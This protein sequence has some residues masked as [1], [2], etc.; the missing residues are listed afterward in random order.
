MK[1]GGFLVDRVATRLKKM[2][3]GVMTSVRLA[4][5]VCQRTKIRHSPAFLTLTYRPGVTWR[6]RH[7]SELF[8][9]IRHFHKKAG[10]TFRYVWVAEMQE[11]GAVHY[12]AIIWLPVGFSLPKPDER[13]WWP[14]G[15]TNIKWAK[16]PAGY[17]AKYASK[18][19]EPGAPSFPKGIRISGC[20]GLDSEGRIEFRF[21]RAPS[22]ARAFFGSGADIRRITGGRF[23]AVTGL[24]W[25][26]LWRLVK[27]NGVPYLL[28][29]EANS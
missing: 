9:C 13:G 3:H 15:S 7:L 25:E 11:R 14:H 6:P 2:K 28:P 1:Q 5:E 16:K 4:G 8:H 19:E 22:E 26:S 21:W 29:K 18:G 23:D 17:L 10:K 27:I 24:F 20:G 12:H